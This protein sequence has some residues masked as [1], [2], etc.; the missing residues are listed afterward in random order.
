[1]DQRETTP[2]MW[3]ALSRVS[4]P[5]EGQP[6]TVAPPGESL[7]EPPTAYLYAAVVKASY[8]N[9]RQGPGVEYGVIETYRFGQRVTVWREQDGWA[10]VAPGR[11]VALR[12]LTR[13]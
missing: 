4:W 12:W 2:A 10:E 9:V 1:M 13:I 11:W 8:L 5:V 7:P 3:S 6:W